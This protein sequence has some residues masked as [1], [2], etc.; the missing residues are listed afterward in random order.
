MPASPRLE[1][2][3]IPQ[4]FRFAGLHCGIKTDPAKKDL[5]VIL[6]DVPC[7]AAGVFTQNRICAAPVQLSRKRVPSAATVGVLLNSGNANA[8]TGEKGL[9]DAERMAGL[10]A[11]QVG[12]APEQVLVCSTG[13]IGRHLPMHVIEPG[14]FQ[15]A[16]V[17]RPDAGALYDA[18]HAIMTTDTRIKVSYRQV[19]IQGQSYRF[20]GVAKGAAMIG[21]NMA[22]MLG[23][24]CTDA[25][26]LPQ[27][28]QTQLRQATAKTFNC[29]S[30]EGHMSTND[31]VLLLANGQGGGPALQG[32]A[33]DQFGGELAALCEDLAVAIVADAEG[34]TKLL[35]LTVEGLPTDADAHRV[36][37][38]VAESALVKTALFGNDPNWGRIVSAAGYAGVP[39]Q[40]REL[41][42]W[43][44]DYLLY[45]QGTPKPVDVSA[46]GQYL[47]ENQ[48]IRARLVFTLGTGHCKFWTSDL[49][50]EYVRLN[51]D[52][53]T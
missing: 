11:A 33:L 10:L 51:A 13:I 29:I 19:T 18:A 26:L 27:D 8:C 34:I 5:A 2:W 12:A 25:P 39:F 46:V 35:T 42:L 7:A 4:G 1:E 50:Y 32:S 6:S 38:T 45:E 21:P 16:R 20:A 53:T 22:T 28:L 37:K 47:K 3:I 9:R 48:D 52:Y 36:A 44:G 30:V 31:T 14:I 40:E 24:V 43:L 17:V 23:V 49:S 41:S 15:A